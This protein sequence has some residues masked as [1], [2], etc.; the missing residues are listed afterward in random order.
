MT[1]VAIRVTRKAR[2][3]IIETGVKSIENPSQSTPQHRALLDVFFH[4]RS[5]AVIGATEDEAGVG[6]ALVSNLKQTSFSGD[7]Y[8][9]NPN[10]SSILGVRCY[11]SISEVADRAD[12][13][14]IATPART[15]PGIVREC[16]AAGV[17]GAVI[18][19][20]GFK[21]IGDKGSET[22]FRNHHA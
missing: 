8:P 3:S 11:S 19:S 4:P 12:L 15:V 18:I 16:V 21:E 14:V 2:S 20:A 13:A 1:N 17:E 6:R 22:L 9:V 5:V 7:I 10:R